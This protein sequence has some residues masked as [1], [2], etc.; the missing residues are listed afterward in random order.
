MTTLGTTEQQAVAEAT[1]LTVAQV[2]AWDTATLTARADAWSA[3][4][5]KLLTF[6]DNQDRAVDAGRDFWTG[7]AAE[8]MRT[9]HDQIRTSARTFIA[10]L[11]DGA[12]AAQSGASSLESAKSAVVNAVKTAEANGYEIADDGTVT[13][14]AGTHQTLLSQLPDAASYS[15]AAG[16]LQMD[17]DASTVTVK[18]ALTQAHSA[19]AAVAEAITTAFTNLPDASPIIATGAPQSIN[20]DIWDTTSDEQG[21]AILARYLTGGGDWYI[22]SDPKWSEYMMN[23]QLL[24][25]QLEEPVTAAATAAVQGYLQN[26]NA[27]QAGTPQRLQMEIENGE[28]IIGY[29]YLHGTNHDVGGFTFVPN[30]TVRDRGDGTYEVTMF[31][32]YTWNDTIDANKQYESDQDKNRVAEAISLGQ[33]DPYDIHINW[34]ANTTLIMDASGRVISQTGY[35]K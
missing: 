1:G 26:G 33:A 24:R 27:S 10:A 13:I 29:Q 14:S 35:P 9:K 8:A 20:R 3:Q 32:S 31:N 23:N 18:Q 11:Q 2:L 34:N 12:A 28:Q 25:N 16:A 15:T 21:R 6:D 4:T 30:S 17:A 22:N 7:T 19:A 5:T